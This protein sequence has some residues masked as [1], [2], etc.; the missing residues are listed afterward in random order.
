MKLPELS[1][2]K[3]DRYYNL[4]AEYDIAVQDY[5]ISPTEINNIHKKTALGDLLLFCLET[6]ADMS[7][8]KEFG[9]ARTMWRDHYG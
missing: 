6:V 7:G 3:I 2:A 1:V 8:D 4:R 5:R 9:S